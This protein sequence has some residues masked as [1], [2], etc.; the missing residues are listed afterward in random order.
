VPPP[1]SEP[2]QR[3]RD[4]WLSRAG[5][6]P[7]APEL[8]TVDRSAAADDDQGA[9]AV[10][11]ERHQ[12]A[13]DR[14]EWAGLRE[15]AARFGCAASTVVLTAYA[16]VIGA[17]S[18]RPGFTLSLTSYHRPPRRLG[19]VATVGLLAVDLDP[20]LPRRLRATAIQSRHSADFEHRR[21][22]AAQVAS[23]VARLHGPG[24]GR[25]PVTF[26][27]AV[28]VDEAAER[29][30]QERGTIPTEDDWIACHAR[31]S[32]D[33]LLVTWKS[34]R[35]VFPLGLVDAMV[36]VFGSLLRELATDDEAWRTTRPVRLPP[37]QAQRRRAVNATAGPLPAA[38]L[39][40]EVVAQGARTP[41][42]PAV[43]AADAAVTYRELLARAGAVAETLRDHGCGAGAIVA[44]AVEKSAA[45]VVAVFGALLAGAAYL[46]LDDGQPA[47]R[48]NRILADAGVRWVLVSAR[49]A[50][51]PWP[52]D[53][54]PIRVDG[55]ATPDCDVPGSA[56]PPAVAPDDLAYVIYTSGSTGVPK[57]VEISHRSALNTVADINR[58]FEVGPADRV[59]GLTPLS[60]DLSVYD[61]FG[62]LAV[63]GCLVL[64]RPERRGD[65]AHWAELAA[66]HRVTLW[67]SVP[68]QLR[69]LADHLEGTGA[70][71][72]LDAMRLAMV[73]GDWIPISLPDR[74]RALLPE[75]RLVSLGGATEA[76]IWSIWYPIEAVPAGWPSIPYGTPLTNQTCHVLDAGL[77][78]RPDWVV[79]EL[80]IGGAGLALGY[81]G[82]PETTAHRF[83]R[84]PV[85]GEHL[86]R[87]GDL[88][89]YHPDGVI[90]LL[91]REDEQVKIRGYRIEPA[92]V[93]AALAGH[94]AVREA[95][96]TTAPDAAGDP[97]LIAY[98]V[99]T[100]ADLPG[101]FELRG[102]LQRIVPEY[103]VPSAFVALERMPLTSNG[104]VDRRALPI[105]DGVRPGHEDFAAPQTAVE[106]AVAQIWAEALSVDAIG[107]HEDFF[108]L[109]G[110]SMLATQV[111]AETRARL[112]VKASVRLVFDEPTI[113]GF[114]R[115]LEQQIPIRDSIP[116][117]RPEERQREAG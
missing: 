17:W 83:V 81:L 51:G 84:H 94:P 50:S 62:P 106:Q 19:E 60:F 56:A 29:A 79:G 111:V 76:A 13:L 67:N 90:E 12:I 91:G 89:R 38:L 10:R 102:Y 22:P 6:L 65:P 1:A 16:E 26:S 8:P 23:E 15:R 100:G 42:A 5:T 45:Q 88:A 49:T 75:L 96:V 63:G 57:G 59:L 66:Q 21:F 110:H 71:K 46:P 44:V 112:G 109:G 80:F 64:P 43:L 55:V 93:E 52:P 115:A 34:Q 14:A 87:T 86:Y 95:V 33:G 11:F 2:E 25:F 107:I 32:G 114:A 92:E 116:R 82:D 20:Q 101:A 85:T 117:E 41:D 53:V 3:D 73:S 74:I 58:R 7:P 39:H 70:L 104:K 68:A 103:M 78:P 28:E 18:R 24:A 105:P 4:Y 27:S 31:R 61:L 77:R 98:W 97:R 113:R 30:G 72:P 69:M 108:E 9:G 36:G 35:G 99:S 37:D 40:E 54:T 47:V 48:Q